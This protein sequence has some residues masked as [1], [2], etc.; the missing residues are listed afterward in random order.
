MIQNP[1]RSAET[2]TDQTHWYNYYAGYSRSFTK[3]ALHYCKLPKKS[4]ILDPWNGAG[5]TTSTCANE[6]YSSIGIDLNPVMVLIAKSQQ[7]TVTDLHLEKSKLLTSR[8]K[9][10]VDDIDSLLNWFDKESVEN[11]RKIEKFILKGNEFNSI[12][13]KTNSLS[14]IQCLQYVALFNIVRILLKSFIPSNPTWIKKAKINEEKISIEW[15]EI[16]KNFLNEV[17]KLECN[18]K[19]KNKKEPLIKTSD[20]TNLPIED[21]SIDLVISSPPYC[22]RIDYAVATLPELSILAV[23]GENEISNI[24]RSLM[25]ATTVPKTL[26][27]NENLGNVCM[28]FL[29]KVN[30]HESLASSGYYYKNFYQ[31]FYNLRL[32][33]NEISRVLKKNSKCFLVVQDSFYKDIHC[34]L[35][36]IIIDM[37]IANGL[38]HVNTYK[39]KSKNNM[40]NINPKGKKYR[41]TTK[42]VE[43]VIEIIKKRKNYGK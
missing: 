40:A 12:Y 17:R 26:P 29:N 22:T 18:I 1:K 27:K 9:V 10:N 33:I 31:Y 11:I 37:F 5:T 3:S 21:N 42:A 34:D 35:E 41:K 19:I 6:G 16:R 23:K 2:V 13:E 25:G 4:I 20:S 8:F 39:F 38:H 43:S 30:K 32:S 24:R 36:K 15:F 7:T 28:D 14:N